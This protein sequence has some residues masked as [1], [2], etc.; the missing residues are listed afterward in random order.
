VKD[1]VA[2]LFDGTVMAKTALFVALSDLLPKSPLLEHT[3]KPK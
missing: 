1:G 2:L 3:S